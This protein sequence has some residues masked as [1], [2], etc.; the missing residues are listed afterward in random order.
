M[1]TIEDVQSEIVRAGYAYWLAVKGERVLPLRADFDPLIEIPR[2]V[3]NIIVFDVLREPL[4]FVYRL[5]GTKVRT[6]LMQDLTG[7]RMSNIEFQRP[8]SV[9]WSHHVWVVENVA[10]RFMRPPYVGP[11]KDFLFIEAVILP[12]GSGASV[13]KLMVFV[14]FIR[15]LRL[16]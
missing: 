14:D 1:D 3:P 5:I 9:I 12:C 11:H 8:P 16:H 15:A 4:D 2:L 10:P 13:E 7:A 6:H